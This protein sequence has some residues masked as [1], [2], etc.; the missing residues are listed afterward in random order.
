MVLDILDCHRLDEDSLNG[1]RDDGL[2]PGDD[3]GGDRAVDHVVLSQVSG[4]VPSL[5]GLVQSPWGRRGGC[6]H[7]V[8]WRPDLSVARSRSL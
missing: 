2:Q 8:G 1:G 7:P 6:H 5:E 4:T 3:V